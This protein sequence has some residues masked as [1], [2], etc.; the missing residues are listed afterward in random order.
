MSIG[1]GI[2]LVAIGAVLTFALNVTVDWIDLDLV[3]YILMI[4][5]AV[6]IIFGLVFMMRRRRSISTT[7]TTTDPVAGQR[8][9]RTEDQAPPPEV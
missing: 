1:L 6:V 7:S 3:G 5:G 8:V 9:T 4:A 2:L